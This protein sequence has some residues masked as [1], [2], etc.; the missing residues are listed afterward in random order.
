M[1]G[2]NTDDVVELLKPLK[3]ECATHIYH[4]PAV[5]NNKLFMADN[6][7]FINNF[8]AI[9]SIHVEQFSKY[10]SIHWVFVLCV[11]FFFI[12]H[13]ST[14]KKNIQEEENKNVS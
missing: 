2:S 5:Q 3:H 1:I 14:K 6:T 4:P 8:I 11:V 9:K 13:N 7:Q 12:V 10:K